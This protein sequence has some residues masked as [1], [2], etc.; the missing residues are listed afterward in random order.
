VIGCVYVQQRARTK[1]IS[2]SPPPKMVSTVLHP[3]ILLTKGRQ[4]NEQSRPPGAP[5]GGQQQQQ[6]QSPPQQQQQQQDWPSAHRLGSTGR[7]VLDEDDVVPYTSFSVSRAEASPNAAAAT[8][9]A[10]ASAV[11]AES[12]VAAATAATTTRTADVC[13][14]PM[15]LFFLL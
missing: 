7:R 11:T 13:G 6:Q 8:Q 5:S 15:Y 1:P 2:F 3:C 12:V 10:A 14:L 9:S 4:G